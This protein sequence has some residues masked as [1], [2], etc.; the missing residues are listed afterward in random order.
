MTY[1]VRLT[2]LN[3]FALCS[4]EESLSVVFMGNVANPFFG[5]N[6]EFPEA[7]K[8]TAFIIGGCKWVG[9][10]GPRGI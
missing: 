5:T 1:G 4:F 8:E 2:R 6:A 9:G 7:E 10:A 3:A